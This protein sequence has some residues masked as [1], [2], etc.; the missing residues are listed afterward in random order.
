MTNFW[1]SA[2]PAVEITQGKNVADV[3]KEEGVQHFIFSSLLN[4]SKTTNGRL[5]NVPHFDGKAEIEAYIRDS[6]VPATFFLA[7]YFMSNFTQTLQRS[8]KDGEVNYAMALPVTK[9]AKLPLVDIETDAG[10]FSSCIVP[11]SGPF[12]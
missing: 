4:V 12:Y 10:V 1:E 5:T 3:A 11:D 7:G 2:T 6:G 8:E 9:D